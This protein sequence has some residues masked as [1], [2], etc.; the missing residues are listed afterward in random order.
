MKDAA[1][2]RTLAIIFQTCC[3]AL[4]CSLSL[5]SCASTPMDSNEEPVVSRSP[6]PTNYQNQ[7][8]QRIQVFMAVEDL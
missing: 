3:V 2:L 4:V 1:A 5:A 8:R 6:V 7:R